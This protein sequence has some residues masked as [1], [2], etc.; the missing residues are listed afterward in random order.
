MGSSLVLKLLSAGKHVTIL[1]RG[2]WYFDSKSRIEPYVEHLVCD[3]TAIYKC[4]QLVNS[5]QYYNAVVDFS[6]YGSQNIQS[7]LGL[8]RGR[9]GRYIYIS[10]D[11]VY[12]V[13]LQNPHGGPSREEDAVRPGN[14]QERDTLN[15]KDNYGHEKLACEESLERE[16]EQHGIHYVSL[17]LPDV[18]G[19]RDTTN[20]FW[21]Y[22]IWLQ[23]HHLGGSRGPIHL[24]PRKNK[25]LSF[26]YSEDVAQLISNLLNAS[27]DVYNQAYN[28]AFDPV[29]L[30][31]FLL[32]MAESLGIK[33]VVFDRTEKANTHWYPSVLRGPVN[34]T[35]ISK[36]LSWT[37]SSLKEAVRVSCQFYKDAMDVPEFQ[38]RRDAIMERYLFEKE[39]WS[40]FLKEQGVTVGH[41]DEL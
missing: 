8:L 38:R 37:P 27:L 35:K 26:V 12:E 24:H 10:S 19:P 34:I 16:R 9:Y 22:Q 11:S 7:I 23:T 3:R 40:R 20:R 32:T 4:T 15:S 30:E 17:R 21:N 29:T 25:P 18:I 14:K 28:V 13:C 5:T 6:S 2:T 41:H 33:N 39:T 1:N 31:E 36:K